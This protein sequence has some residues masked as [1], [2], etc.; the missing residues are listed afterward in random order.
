MKRMLEFVWGRAG[1]A[2][3]SVGLWGR[4]AATMLIA[5]VLVAMAAR[6][7]RRDPVAPGPSGARK[8]I[9]REP[10]PAPAPVVVPAPKFVPAS[11]ERLGR[12]TNDS[13]LTTLV[14]NY[15]VAVARSDA[16]TQQAMLAGLKRQPARSRELLAARKVSLDVGSA[17]AVDRALL[18]LQ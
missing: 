4:R 10:A 16:A 15:L 14:D 13:A 17:S 3:S 1:D 8:P 12:A 5:V 18:E 9:P 7:S 11:A 2:E 6:A